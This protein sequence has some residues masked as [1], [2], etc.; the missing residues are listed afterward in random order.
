[1]TN[2]QK[3]T[4]KHSKILLKKTKKNVKNNNLIIHISGASGAGK[5]TLGEKLSEEFSDKIIVK[6]LD[7]LRNE[8]LKEE[9]KD[10]KM[11]EIK[12]IWN[13]GKYQQWIDNYI[14]KNK[15][16]PIVLVGLNNIPWV[17]KFSYYNMHSQHNFYINLDFDTI[18]KQ[19]CSRFMDDIFV[20]YR[21]KVLDN[22]IKHKNKEIKFIQDM[23]SNNC[24]YDEILEINKQFN[25]DY[26]EQKYKFMSR[27]DIYEKVSKILNKKIK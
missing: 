11:D 23:F 2:T 9:Y 14:D 8:F 10:K 17:N 18:F 3:K 12:E 4:K 19:R 26:K 6:D 15:D 16:K 13:E 1:M 24:N 25:K 21:E 22:I 5:T 7:R 27:E 20:K